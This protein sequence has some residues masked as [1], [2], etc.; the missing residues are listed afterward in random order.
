[1]GSATVTVDQTQHAGQWVD[2]GS[3]PLSASTAGQSVTL[4]GSNAGTVVADAIKAVRDNSGDTNTARHIL[5]YRYDADGNQT[6]IT[7]T[8][9]DNPP[10]PATIMGYDQLDRLTGVTEDNASGTAVHTTTYG[11]DAAS[12]LTSRIHDAGLTAA[13]YATYTPNNLNQLAT[14]S[15]ATTKDDPSPQVTTF[16]YTPDGQT[17]TEVKPNGNTLTDAYYANNL[18]QHSHETT[19]SGATVAEHTYTYDPNGNMRTNTQTL[20]SADPGGGAL[21]STLTYTYDPMDWLLTVNGGGSNESYQHDPNGNV[22]SQT[23]GSTQTSY[24][25][26]HNRLAQATSGGSTS[27]YN[28][29]PLGRL[30]TI[31]S[32]STVQQTNTY[33]GFDNLAAQTT[34]SGTTTYSYDSLNRM[35]SQTTGGTTTSF[36]YLGLTSDLATET[37]GG[38]LTR[39]YTYTPSDQRLSQTKYGSGDPVT[40]YYSY[41]AHS[42][43]EALTGSD[44][45]TTSTYGYTA[46]GQPD[47]SMF[48]GADKNTA[49]P[50]TDAQPDNTYRYN[51]MRWNSSTGQYDMGFRT[52]DPGL[53]QFLSRDMYDGALANTGLTTD[54]FTG[55]PY[56]FGQ[57]NPITNIE[58]DG[59]MLVAPPSGCTAGQ[60]QC[61]Q[62]AAATNAALKPPQPSHT[63]WWSRAIH[64]AGE[65]TGVNAAIDCIKHPTWGKCLQAAAQ[66]G[67]TVFTVAT[68]GAGAEAEIGVDLAVEGLSEA[69]GAV[70][71]E[72]AAGA[73]DAGAAAADVG[74]EAADAGAAAGEEAT[75]A[76]DTGDLARTTCGGASFTAGTKV[77]LASG[78]AIPIRQL[79]VGDKV[80][81]TN[82]MTGKTQAEQVTAVLVHHDTNRYNLKIREH[83]KTSVIHTTSNHPFW[84]PGAGDHAGR[85][86]K[87]AALKYGTHLRTPSGSD[88]AVVTGGWI[89]SQRDGW[90]WD[91]TVPG[92]NDH[93]FYISTT[94][95]DVL[96]HNVGGVCP[97]QVGRA[98]ENSAGI[99]KN[100][101][102]ISINGRTR[103]PDELT[104]TTI[105]EVKNRAYQYLSTQIRDYLDYAKQTGRTFNL[106]VRA[107]TQ[108]SV[109]LQDL[110]DSGDINLIRNL[111]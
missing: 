13:S 54:P 66:V 27:N 34:T 98:G 8:S 49:T 41:N 21:T 74:A 42:D 29:D 87:A 48:S 103:I 86:V 33:D 22:T 96:V 58:Y 61:R 28:Y 11:Y 14:E 85:W 37:S 100:S 35:A 106:Y 71:A 67:A 101:N 56:A 84:V 60:A 72:G 23:I 65:V 25:Y 83:G 64:F 44:G 57:A 97:N 93:D 110:V 19:T 78:A 111:P 39:T 109:P 91:L 90:M 7:D 30:D 12:N 62:I 92:N 38:S 26:N 89:P 16:T 55:S 68:L 59:H 69:G 20:M 10:V 1:G 77:L 79:K 104:G 2:L 73:V 95:A 70:A 76:E 6:L 63:S 18:L 52:Y 105:G 82:T 75:A 51:A 15:D 3:W 9:P 88:T 17:K 99:T 32:G 24:T 108:L 31:T 50:G 40:E 107:S 36:A 45:T 5:S 46:Y 47:T 43:V 81:A 53:N 80:L 102:A 94:A 4:A